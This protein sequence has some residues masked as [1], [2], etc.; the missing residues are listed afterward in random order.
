MIVRS[1]SGPVRLSYCTNVHPAETLD[2]LRRVLA[3]TAAAV[4]A[5]VASGE[6]F[7]LGLWLPAAVVRELGDASARADFRRFLDAHGFF[8]YTVNAFPH[9]G[10]HSPR[11]KEDVFRPTWLEEERLAYTLRAAEV[12]SDLLPSGE[13]GSI[14]THTGQWKAWGDGPEVRRSVAVRLLEA[15]RGLE[16]L[17]RRTGR[18]VSLALEPEPLSTLETTPEVLEFFDAHV[19]MDARRHLGVCYDVC[20][21][22]VQFEEATWS[23]SALAAVGVPVHKVQLSSALEA[24][25]AA[26]DQR[27]ALAAL[28]EPRYLHQVVTRLRDGRLERRED[29]G[30]PLPAE[31][32]L[33]CHFHVPVH[34]PTLGPLRTTRGELERAIDALRVGGATDHLEVETYTWGLLPLEG[35]DLGRGLVRE[36]EWCRDRL[37]R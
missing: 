31:G 16:S 28:A 37:T 21:Q 19:P 8:A 25:G 17:E 11:V 23:L 10:F 2:G 14:S 13:R 9:G 3:H 5:E 26:P 36:L 24:D 12:L 20:H 32:T 33:R 7:G 6:P 29:L 34:E 1:P 15:A 22:A 4:A 27:A 35:A 30:G 18:Y